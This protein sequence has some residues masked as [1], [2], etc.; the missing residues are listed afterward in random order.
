MTVTTSTSTQPSSTIR[1]VVARHPVAFMLLAMF[2]VSFA[3]LIPPALAGLALE[4]FLLGAVLFGQ[5][6]PAVLVTGAVGGR[7]AVRELFGRVFRWRVHPGWYLLALLGIPVAALLVS[8]AVFG[9]GALRALVTDP[10]VVVAYLVSLSILPVVNLWEETAWMGV[11]QARLAQY[12]GPLFAAV[13]TGPLFGLLHL[14]LQ[15]GKPIGDLLLGMLFLMVFAIP[16][17]MV[18]GWLYNVT[19]GSVLLVAITHATFNATNNTKL[20]TAAAPG[21]SLL[22]ATPWVVIVAWALLVAVLTRG[23]LAGRRD[24]ASVIEADR[25]DA[26]SSPAPTTAAPGSAP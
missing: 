15:I 21:R 9:P 17:R 10:S 6:L 7:P 1:Q 16:L 11:V 20:L 25:T 18:L 26:V 12:R 14:P 4:P 5:L 3:L 8:A 22:T 2:G 24:R 23:R 13:V 19:G